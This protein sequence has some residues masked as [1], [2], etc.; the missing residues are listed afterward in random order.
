MKYQHCPWNR[1]LRCYEDN[2]RTCPME[3][4]AWIEAVDRWA[5]TGRTP[6]SLDTSAVLGGVNIGGSEVV[7]VRA[8]NI[9]Q[10]F[11][12]PEAVLGWVVAGAD[13]RAVITRAICDDLKQAYRKWKAGR[14]QE[15]NEKGSNQELETLL[16]GMGRAIL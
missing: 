7:A 9:C 14:A 5:L 6:R 13:G 8:A 12:D 2:Q 11:H 16:P 1:R 15:M 10:L 4:R 3:M